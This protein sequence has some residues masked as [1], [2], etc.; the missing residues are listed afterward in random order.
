MHFLG[1]DTTVT[2][3]YNDTFNRIYNDTSEGIYNNTTTEWNANT[4][5]T[6]NITERGGLEEIGT[7]LV[8]VVHRTAHY[9]WN[10]SHNGDQRMEMFLFCKTVILY[11]YKRF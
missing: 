4:T 5:M 9:D 2:V 7:R 1:Y 10:Y 3:P 6:S 11:L 8:E